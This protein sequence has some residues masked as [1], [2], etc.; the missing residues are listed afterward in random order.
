M[1]LHAMEQEYEFVKRY[2]DHLRRYITLVKNTLPMHRNLTQK[3]HGLV[4]ELIGSRMELARLVEKA[5][6]PDIPGRLRIL[7]GKDPSQNELW[8][9]LGK[10]ERRM[11]AKEEDMAEKNLT[12]EA[13]C[14]L[15]DSL[16]ATV[17]LVNI[18][19]QPVLSQAGLCE[20]SL[21]VH[22]TQSAE[23]MQVKEYVV[24]DDERLDSV[25]LREDTLTLA[26]EVNKIK[27]RL[28]QLRNQMKTIY[29][30]L[31]VCGAERNDL[32]E[33]VNTSNPRRD[34]EYAP[35]M[36]RNKK[37]IRVWWF[38]LYGKLEDLRNVHECET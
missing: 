9:T 25:S 18:F 34:C 17:V 26:T 28:L 23:H 12:Y 14:R 10:L 5:E 11:A 32:K 6:D 15:V 22:P 30:E 36:S 13:V 21:I 31:V 27:S 38:R 4:H 16:Q 8:I 35:R 1:T 24:I 29:A 2:R 7:G 19:L 33:Q 37:E 20:I 3:L